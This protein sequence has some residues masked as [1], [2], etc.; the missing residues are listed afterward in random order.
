MSKYI[1]VTEFTTEIVLDDMSREPSSCRHQFLS[2]IN[3]DD[4]IKVEDFKKRL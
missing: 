4:I 3:I 1:H 2:L